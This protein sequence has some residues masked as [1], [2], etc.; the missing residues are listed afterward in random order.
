MSVNNFFNKTNDNHE[1]KE[2]NNQKA[3]IASLKANVKKQNNKKK[4]ETLVCHGDGLG[5]Q[6]EIK[7]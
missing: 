6:N 5:I 2:N 7:Y 4:I 1:E 3:F